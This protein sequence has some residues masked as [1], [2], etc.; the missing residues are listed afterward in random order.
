[1]TTYQNSS[2]YRRGSDSGGGF[3]GGDDRR[4]SRGGPGGGG[5]GPGGRRFGGRRRRICFCKE[6]TVDYKDVSSLRRFITDRGRIESGKKTGNCAKCQRQLRQ[7]IKR[8]RHLALLPFAGDHLRVT[9]VI[10]SSATGRPEVDGI[11]G[12]E[13]SEPDYDVDEVEEEDTDDEPGEFE[14]SDDDS[15]ESESSDEDVSQG[16]DE[17]SE[18]GDGDE[19][20]DEED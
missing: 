7:A 6:G 11:D 17:L 2:P 20:D 1:M 14:S 13:D 12:V 4:S 8:A 16:E 18:P 9:S 10:S 5:G 15:D 19:G 3:R